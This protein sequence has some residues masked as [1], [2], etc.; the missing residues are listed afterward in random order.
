MHIVYVYVVSRFAKKCYTEAFPCEQSISLSD[1]IRTLLL[2]VSQAC[3]GR[4][5]VQRLSHASPLSVR[6]S[7]ISS[8]YQQP[9]LRSEPHERQSFRTP[10]PPWL[11]LVYHI[12]QNEELA[13]PYC[14]SHDVEHPHIHF[15]CMMGYESGIRANFAGTYGKSGCRSSADSF[16]LYDGL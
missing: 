12:H 16:R 8:G 9:D 7:P 13:G 10:V 3:L 4:S 1:P 15:A 14:D 5:A 11:D 2:R 6:L